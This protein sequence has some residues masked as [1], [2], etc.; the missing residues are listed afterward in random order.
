MLSARNSLRELERERKRNQKGA[1]SYGAP[2]LDSHPSTRR[3]S[4]DRGALA[5]LDRWPDPPHGT[6]HP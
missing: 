5:Q 2:N 4:E 1:L 6:Y 3:G